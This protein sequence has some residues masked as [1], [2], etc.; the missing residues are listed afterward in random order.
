MLL[1][2]GVAGCDTAAIAAMP[3]MGARALAQ[4]TFRA[5]C[6]FPARSGAFASRRLSKGWV[7]TIEAEMIDGRHFSQRRVSPPKH[8]RGDRPKQPRRV[9][10][11]CG[12][13]MHS[14]ARWWKMGDYGEPRGATL[15]EEPLRL[16]K[17]CADPKPAPRRRFSPVRFAPPAI[18]AP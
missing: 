17:Q 14:C 4:F 12:G 5:E 15:L 10:Q 3:T 7:K 1:K 6:G 2:L 16:I 9:A 13:G 8:E 11:E 18:V